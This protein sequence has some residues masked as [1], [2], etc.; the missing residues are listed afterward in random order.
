MDDL[1]RK[2]TRLRGEVGA[3]LSALGIEPWLMPSGG[4]YLW[5]R[6]P[7]GM[8]S[9]RL[10]RTGLERGLVLAPGNVFSPSE[11]AE[12]FMRFNAT[13]MPDRAFDH[14]ARLLAE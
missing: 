7:E 8:D 3:R 6:L 2:L 10:A 13:Q 11:T 12:R 14:L 9:R 5:C 1:R 4:F